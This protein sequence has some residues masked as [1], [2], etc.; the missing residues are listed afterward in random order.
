M[1]KHAFLGTAWEWLQ[2]NEKKDLESKDE[3]NAYTIHIPWVEHIHSSDT[4]SLQ[5]ETTNQGSLGIPHLC[6][7]S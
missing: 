7:G 6:S 3:L 5:M 1:E 4:N 2:L